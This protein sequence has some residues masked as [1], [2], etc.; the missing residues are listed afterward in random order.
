MIVL[1]INLVVDK[2]L[3]ASIYSKIAN[4]MKLEDYMLNLINKDI[5]SIILLKDNLYFNK[6]NGKIYRGDTE[7]ILAKT[8]YILFK[9]LLDN[10]NRLVT[11]DEI[12]SVI[13]ENKVTSRFTLRNHVKHLRNKTDFDLI[14][15]QSNCG[16]IMVIN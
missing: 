1:P 10:C 4:S 16:Y 11:F 9:L 2:N 6:E 3:L 12:E 8:E 5:N 13:W 7:I 15:N 14:R